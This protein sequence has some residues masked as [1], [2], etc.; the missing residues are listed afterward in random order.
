MSVGPQ[1]PA[2][3]QKQR[4]EQQLDED[5]DTTDSEHDVGPRNN[6]FFHFRFYVLCMNSSFSIYKILVIFEIY[7][8]EIEPLMFC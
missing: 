1:L 5:S 8:K 4:E 6:S 7:Q 3:L 2:H